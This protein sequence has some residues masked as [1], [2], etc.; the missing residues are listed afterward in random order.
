[1]QVITGAITS[2]DRGNRLEGRGSDEQV[3]L[4]DNKIKYLISLTVAG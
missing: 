3:D 1:M 2:I 4:G